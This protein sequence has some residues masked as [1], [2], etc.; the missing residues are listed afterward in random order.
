MLP[1]ECILQDE[2]SDMI[3]HSSSESVVFPAP[4][5]TGKT[6]SVTIRKSLPN[7]PSSGKASNNSTQSRQVGE[8]LQATHKKSTPPPPPPLLASKKRP[9]LE[10]SNKGSSFPPLIPKKK[11]ELR[12]QNRSASTQLA[13]SEKKSESMTWTAGAAPPRVP[14]KKPDLSLA[15]DNS[16]HMM[17]RRRLLLPGKSR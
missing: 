4:V 16:S 9:Q 7:L 2:I 8:F 1:I 6:G 3:I 17:L 15:I 13:V 14:R 12:S 5:S 11:S 10:T